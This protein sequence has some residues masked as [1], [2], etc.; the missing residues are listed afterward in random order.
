MR[1]GIGIGVL[2]LFVLM[3]FVTSCD[4]GLT[5]GVVIDPNDNCV[6]LEDSQRED[7]Y[8]NQLKCSKITSVALRDS[9]VAQL[10]LVKSDVDVCDLISRDNT[11]GFCQFQLINVTGT[12]TDCKNIENT[13]WSGNCH[14]NFALSDNDVRLCG[15]LSGN[16]KNLCFEQI[17][18]ATNDY[19]VC[20]ALPDIDEARCIYEI[21]KEIKDEKACD[22]LKGTLHKSACYSRIA[23][24]KE[25]VTLCEKVI[26]P[27]VKG[28]CLA[29]FE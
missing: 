28:K 20:H 26:T 6:S 21:A 18:F 17:A 22:E 24:L 8:L 3:F 29:A 12:A 14:L 2:G 11:K 7:C 16:Q 9:C 25:D 27:L 10:A 19:F 13:F 5:G 15:T 23:Q 4:F 1:W